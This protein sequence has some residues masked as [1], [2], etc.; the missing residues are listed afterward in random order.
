VSAVV[1]LTACTAGSGAPQSTS[2]SA[3]SAA[4]VASSG[5]A[6]GA[7]TGTNAWTVTAADQAGPAFETVAHYYGTQ[8]IPIPLRL[9]VYPLQR[10]QGRLLLT[11]DFTPE[12]VSQ[13][14]SLGY[15]SLDQNTVGKGAL[16]GISLIDTT[17]K[18]RYGPIRHGSPKGGAYTSDVDTEFQ[19][20]GT[21]Y[22]VGA[23]FPAPDAGVTA[24]SVDLQLGGVAVGVPISNDTQPR[25]G[26][27]AGIG[28]QPS[29]APA[30]SAITGPSSTS[31]PQLV[32]WPAPVPGP[33][34]YVDRHDLVTKVVGGT[35]N[36][37]G[38]RRQGLVTA[39]ADV[40]FDF[41]SSTLTARGRTLVAQAGGLLAAQADPAKPVDVI[42]YT[43]S[44]GGDAYNQA[45][46]TR[47]AASVVAA[48]KAVAGA[49]AFTLRPSGRGAQA[50][51]AANTLPDGRDN[52]D[53]RALNRRVEMLFAP[54]LVSTPSPT[55]DPS[56]QPGGAGT[57]PSASPGFVT[58]AGGVTLPRANVFKRGETPTPMSAT[59]QPLVRD[60][61]LT[62]VQLD[63]TADKEVTVLSD[64]S[65][66]FH[67]SSDLS[68][69][70]VVDPASKRAYVPA[71]DKDDE[72]RVLCTY[73]R[74]FNSAGTYH[75]AFYVDG[76]PTSMTSG[77]VA[78]AQ[79]GTAT[80]VPVH[81]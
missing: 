15:F 27:V 73:T 74:R 69:F 3:A 6:T 8:G 49:G 4:S 12:G 54:K 16:D 63:I 23:F 70:H 46:S 24:L 41:N 42:G 9:R 68:A 61:V 40:L 71:Y 28:D 37:G 50:P 51:V 30:S 39:N 11:L 55:P 31:Q 48:L 58:S 17:N 45:L 7:N 13:V 72:H 44:V 76:L 26:V 22:R 67:I 35:V 47:R 65:T 21:V 18:V 75:Y 79:M 81:P 25:A 20:P 66:N 78:L 14:A 43:D 62:L 10:V 29:P 32:T 56:E 1:A 52:P 19:R 80:G 36:S 59:V 34:A 33:D 53:G 5:G 57:S 38:S 64:F 2:S 60:G 77:S